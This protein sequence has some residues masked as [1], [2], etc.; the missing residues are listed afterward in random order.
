MDSYCV[1]IPLILLLWLIFWLARGVMKYRS[2][3]VL[4]AVSLPD[5]RGVAQVTSGLLQ[6][7]VLLYLQL[8]ATGRPLRLW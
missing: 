5:L 2:S 3:P 7:T 4:T 1:N 8:A 6:Q